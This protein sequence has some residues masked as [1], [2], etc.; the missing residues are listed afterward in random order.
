MDS[1][2]LQDLCNEA[3]ENDLSQWAEESISYPD[4]CEAMKADNQSTTRR[5][6]GD[7]DLKP[8]QLKPRSSF[9]Q[10]IFENWGAS[11]VTSL[12]TDPTKS[13]TSCETDDISSESDSSSSSDDT[14]SSTSSGSSDFSFNAMPHQNSMTTCTVSHMPY[15]E[16]NSGVHGLYS[17]QIDIA[18]KLPNG[19]G[20]LKCTN[21]HSGECDVHSGEW[22]MGF[23]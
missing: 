13:I 22:K 6:N 15:K 16:K 17:G 1:L 2:D 20:A 23:L 18:T 3:Y 5:R 11:S 21:V 14:S 19:F 10:R 8:A 9:N 7:D 12:K 4:V